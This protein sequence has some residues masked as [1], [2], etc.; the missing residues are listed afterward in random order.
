[1]T[2]L[3]DNLHHRFTELLR[4]HRNVDIATAW[5]TCGEHLQALADAGRSGVKVRV[6]VGI[7]SNATHPDALEQLNK[8]TRGKLRIVPKG[9]HLFHPKLYLFGRR[10]GAVTGR[11]WI[12]SA[13][14]TEAGFGGHYGA[15]EEIMW[16]VEPGKRAD[17]LADWFDKRWGDYAMD[18]P[19]SEVIRQ[20]TKNWKPPHRAVRTFV[21]GSI[22]RRVELLK[23][24]LRTFDDYVEALSECE[25][26]LRDKN[27]EVFNL[28]QRSYVAAISGRR[29]SCSETRSGK[30]SS[31]RLD[32]NSRGFPTCGL[33]VVG[34]VGTDES[35]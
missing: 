5:A 29:D 18:T 27:W 28:R 6:I 19:V 12:G 24:R 31:P 30:I 2:L 21:S 34:S 16:E 33:E 9:G 7:A 25:G 8:I 14:F 3:G 17:A 4:D 15:N 22:N 13:N 23:D 35:G 11:A 1:M 20:Y 10:D 32:G 26:M